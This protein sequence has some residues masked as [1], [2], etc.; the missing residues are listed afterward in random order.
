MFGLELTTIVQFLGYPGLAGV[1]FLE[2]G[3]FFGFFLPGASFLFVAGMLA[4]LGFFSIWVLLPLL[5]FAAIL[6]D[7]VGYWFGAWIGK[8]IYTRPDSRFF[9]QQHVKMAHDFFERYGKASVLLARFVPIARTF[10]PILAGV[11]AMDYRIFLFY[12]VVGAV[13][14]AG[15]FTLL[16]Y[17]IGQ[18]IPDAENYITPII[19]LII[20]LTAIPVFITM[21]K[22]W[23]E[24][25]KQI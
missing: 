1:I 17:F 9:K 18:Y 3:V 25:I 23:K 19:L 20:G 8:A 4:S 22:T 12:N 6:G 11:G 15:G 13:V 5:L 2:S 21:W 16:G 7:N 14:W 24:Q 10:V